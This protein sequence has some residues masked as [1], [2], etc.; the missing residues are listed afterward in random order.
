M[1]IVLDT[2]ILVSAFFWEGNESKIVRK[3]E[4]GELISITSPEILDEL[5]RV[6]SQKFRISKNKINEYTRNILSFSEVV[7]PTGEVKVIKED[8][9]DDLILETACLGKAEVIISGDDHLLK[10]KEF[11]DMEV[12]KAKEI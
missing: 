5:E 11:R 10:L 7:F 8:P 9:A 6:L 1:R 3:C 12:K 2:N 4:K